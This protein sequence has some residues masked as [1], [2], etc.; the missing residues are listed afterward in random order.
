MK[1]KEAVWKMV[2][3]RYI[4]THLGY[5][6]EQMEQFKKNPQNS[7]FLN[8]AP[9]LMGKTVVAEVVESHGCNSRHAVGDRFYFDGFGNLLA[10][11]GPGKICLYALNAV[12][13]QIF[14]VTEF[15]LA[16]ADPNTMRFNRAA[17]FDVGVQCGGFGRIVLEVKVLAR[18]RA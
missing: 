9:H 18:D 4:K 15:L 7:E 13:P 2:G 10:D 17:C 12:V 6:D 8:K 16:G 11:K 1:L 5:N 3:W 14:A